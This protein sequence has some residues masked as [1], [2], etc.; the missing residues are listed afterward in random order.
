LHEQEIDEDEISDIFS[1]LSTSIRESEASLAECGLEKVA[2]KVRAEG[3]T[4]RWAEAYFWINKMR[5]EFS[6]GGLASIN[7]NTL[8]S[9]KAS[10]NNQLL[11][12]K[13]GQSE[14]SLAIKF[15]S[16]CLRNYLY[17]KMINKFF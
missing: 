2:V 10:T 1:Q 14:T 3:S 17:E 16:E 8:T 12:M 11:Y 5:I 13:L 7:L 6:E 9:V 4:D 15:E